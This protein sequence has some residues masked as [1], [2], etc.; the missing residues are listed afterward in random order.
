MPATSQAELAVETGV[1]A[2]LDSYRDTLHGQ[3]FRAHIAKAFHAVYRYRRFH[4]VLVD[5]Y[6]DFHDGKLLL[7][8]G[9]VARR[10]FIG[11]EQQLGKSTLWQLACS[12]EMKLHPL[13]AAGHITHSVNKALRN[14]QWVRRFY[15]NSGGTLSEKPKHNWRTTEGGEFWAVSTGQSPS[16]LPADILYL[17]DLTGDKIQ[18]ESTALYKEH[19]SRMP[20]VMARRRKNPIPGIPPFRM[21]VIH[22]RQGLADIASKYLDLD[23]YYCIILPTLYAPEGCG[24]KET[25]YLGPPLVGP[26]PPQPGED[27]SRDKPWAIKNSTVHSDWRQPGEGLDENDEEDIITAA[28]FE[29][30]RRKNGGWIDEETLAANQ[31]QTPMTSKGGGI[32]QR[33]FFKRT[34]TRPEGRSAVRPWDFGATLGG[35][36]PTASLEMV[37]IEPETYLRHG[38]RAWLDPPRVKLLVAAMAILDG[39]GVAISIPIALADGGDRLDS[40]DRWLREVFGWLGRSR[41]TLH[42]QKV[43]TSRPKG[44]DKTAKFYRVSGGPGSFAD[45]TKPL[46][47]DPPDGEIRQQGR[48]SI[49]TSAWQPSFRDA[50]PDFE[51]LSRQHPELAEM[52]RLALAATGQLQPAECRTL[53]VDPLEWQA[54]ALD[55]CHGMNP[56]SDGND[57]YCDAGGDGFLYLKQYGGGVMPWAG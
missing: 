56:Y 29:R 22:T 28:G 4:D 21:V 17:D 37:R 35:G 39:P 3:S 19:L 41:P 16:S 13:L 34:L 9:Q 5:C 43:A 32:F 36:H 6:Q 44:D 51:K 38:C 2:Q 57:D 11:I 25:W 50:V 33:D 55:Q 54:A 7:P 15:R 30:R 1:A 48:V 42:G 26:F 47:W 24:L 49:V 12:W 14:S 27:V 31:Q 40:Y 18:A 20:E 46:D 8:D 53:N 10:L 52:E 23:H 45:E